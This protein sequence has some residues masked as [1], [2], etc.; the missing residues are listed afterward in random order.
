MAEIRISR[1]HV[2]VDKETKTYIITQ[3]S[4]NPDGTEDITKYLPAQFREL[5]KHMDECEEA[6]Y[7]PAT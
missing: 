2:V 1:F 3:V 6:R 4:S 5:Q 7:K